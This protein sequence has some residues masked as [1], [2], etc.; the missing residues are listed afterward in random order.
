MGDPLNLRL[1]KYDGTFISVESNEFSKMTC[2]DP[3][4]IAELKTAIDKVNTSKTKS[5]SDGV[6]ESLTKRVLKAKLK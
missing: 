4:N 1:V 6:F 5:A 2:F 3:D